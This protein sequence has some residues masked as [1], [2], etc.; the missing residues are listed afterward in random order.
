MFN[1]K[2]TFLAAIFI[3]E[4]GS[5]LCA[6]APSSVAFIVGRAIAG[7][8][9]AGLFSGAVVILSYTRPFPPSNPI[10]EPTSC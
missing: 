1:V 9:T 3:F 5:L 6:V 2:W 10:V 4:V 8:G 7:M